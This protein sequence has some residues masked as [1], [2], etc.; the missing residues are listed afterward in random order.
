MNLTEWDEQSPEKKRGLI[1]GALQIPEQVPSHFL[2]PWIINNRWV[3]DLFVSE[4]IAARDSGK[5]HYSAQ[6][7]Y[8]FLAHREQTRGQHLRFIEHNNAAQTLA[9]I[10]TSIFSLELRGFFDEQGVLA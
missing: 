9:V 8:E 10:V 4:I 5:Q 3:V 2:K 7:I 6:R 1:V